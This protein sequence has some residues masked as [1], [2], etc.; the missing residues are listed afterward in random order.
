M[1]DDDTLLAS[2][3][4]E[5]EIE[6]K[7]KPVK[8]NIIVDTTTLYPHHPGRMYFG[9]YKPPIKEELQFETILV[10]KDP[11]NEQIAYKSMDRI[12]LRMAEKRD[13]KIKERKKNY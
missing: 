7:P 10:E 13:T 8:Y 5:L 3:L 4:E 9:G 6:E 12:R 11:S 2:L 1:E